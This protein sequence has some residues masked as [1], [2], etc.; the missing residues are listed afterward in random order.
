VALVLVT[1]CSVI[2]RDAAWW[3]ARRDSSGLAPDPSRTPEA[4]LQVYAARTVGWRG[5]LA[6]HTW[7]ALKRAGAGE[8][9]RYEVIGWGV[10]RGLPALRV[11]RTGADNWWFGSEPE[12]LLDRRGPEVDPLIDR[13]ENAVAT[14]PYRDSY[15]TW[16][17]PNSNTFVAYVAR[18][19]PELRLTLPPT[20]IGKDFLPGG[21]LGGSA[22]SGSGVQFSLLGLAGVVA[23][24]DDG[25][26]VNVLG[27]TFGL[28]LRRPALKLPGVGRVGARAAAQGHAAPPG[29]HA[30]GRWLACC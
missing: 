4:V 10:E 8:Y 3:E 20:A 22:P 23:G 2:G 30:A 9:T 19:V 27:L 24:W 18:A 13:V 28:D 14:Y 1:G 17:G 16:P 7:I 26:E 12:L 29:E 21:V 5:L 15:R 6:V 25:L 11:N